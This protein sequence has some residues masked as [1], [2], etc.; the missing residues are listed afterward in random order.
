ML[1]K[2]LVRPWLFQADPEAAHERALNLVAALGR[3]RI[4]RDAIE[5]LFVVEDR[6]LHQTLFGIEFPN[7]VGLGAGDDKNALG[8][9]LWPVF[10]FGFVEIGSVTLHP[11]PG[12]EP[13]RL[14]RQVEQCSLINRMG[15]NN[16]GAEAIA[17]R[18]PPPPHRIPIGINVGKNRDV[19][20]ARAGKA[21]RPPSAASRSRRFFCD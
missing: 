7:P 4:A 14:F 20:L 18:I 19:D 16:D 1:Y 17:G 12:T 15:F 6:R 9:E 21:M 8:L 3:H 13:P 2:S 10:G 11:Q 5:S